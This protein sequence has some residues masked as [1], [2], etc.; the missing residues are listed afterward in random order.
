MSRKLKS[1]NARKHTIVSVRM[2]IEHRKM[3]DRAADK[4][5]LDVSTWMRSVALQEYDRLQASWAA[6]KAAKA[7]PAKAAKPAKPAAKSVKKTVEA[8]AA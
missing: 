2:T 4:Q 1:E 5:G 3:F 8:K 7:K 6:N